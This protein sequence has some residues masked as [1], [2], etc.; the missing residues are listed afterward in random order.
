ML[1]ISEVIDRL[2]ANRLF[3]MFPETHGNFRKEVAELLFRSEKFDLGFASDLRAATSSDVV[4]AFVKAGNYRL[5]YPITALQFQ[6]AQGQIGILLLQQKD[7]P[8]TFSY[9]RLVQII[10]QGLI[11]VPAI[12]EV[13]A[14]HD[15]EK[16]FRLETHV[17]GSQKTLAEIQRLHDSTVFPQ[18]AF[19]SFYFLQ[20]LSVSP[21]VRVAAPHRESKALVKQGKTRLFDHYVVRVAPRPEP[22][23]PQGGTHASPSE[24][25]RRAH[26]RRVARQTP[27]AFLAADGSWRVPIKELTVNKGAARVTTH[28]YWVPPDT[29]R[30]S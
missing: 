14:Q 5:P 29:G 1:I 16:P 6:Y 18:Y 20:L 25:T 21:G 13:F 4:R 30:N 17:A 26:T 15:E 27:K 2:K 28:E 19:L 22:A 8:H 3:A 24:H 23:E 10:N 7:A 11:L 12:Y 9:V